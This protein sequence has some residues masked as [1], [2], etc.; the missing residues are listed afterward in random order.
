MVN[1][2][3]LVV[4][5]SQPHPKPYRSSSTIH[6]VPS[7]KSPSS[8]SF[9]TSS[10]LPASPM[11]LVFPVVCSFRLSCSVLRGAASLVSSLTDALYLMR[12]DSITLT[13]FASF[14]QGYLLHAA[15]PATFPDLSKFALIGAAAQLGGI[16][17]MIASLTVVL[18]EATG[19]VILGLPVLITLIP[20]KYIGDCFTEVPFLYSLLSLILFTK[21]PLTGSI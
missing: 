3:D 9:P 5:S 7:M 11:V 12:S 6:H 14:Y 20:A 10:Q 17:R 16:V 4:F 8:S 13:E 19:N 1:T 2:T 21:M 18:M 15:S